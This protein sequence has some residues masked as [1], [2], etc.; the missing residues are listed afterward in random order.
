MA[1]LRDRLPP[2]PLDLIGDV[3]GELEALER[4]LLR[5]G[6]D[7]DR[8]TSARPLIFLGDLIDRGPDSPGVVR[9]V[10][11]LM[12]AG[13]AWCVLG[14]HELNVLLERRREGNGWWWADPTDSWQPGG[15]RPPVPF[16]CA[17]A[18]ADAR[19]ELA[20]L[21]ARMPLTLER[22]DLRV[23]H[24]CWSPEALARL[25]ADGDLAD[26]HRAFDAEVHA[27]L[28]A[29][30]VPA[31]ARAERAAFAGLRDRGTPPTRHLPAAAEED[32]AEQNG[33]PL[34]VLTS[35][36]EREIAPEAVFWVGGRW[37]LVERSPWW[38]A[39]DDPTPVVVGHY[40][41]SRGEAPEDQRVR[42]VF[43]APGPFHWTGKHGQ[44][45]CVDY[46]VGRRYR[47]RHFGGPARGGLAALRWP[48]R[49]LVFD[50]GFTPGD[51]PA[52]AGDLRPRPVPTVGFG[53]PAGDGGG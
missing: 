8:G 50:D 20:D 6:V 28:E 36:A 52:P 14:N 49:E 42:M 51:G 39:A 22:P 1:P 4:L 43:D 21:I 13:I 47:D 48:E 3:H 16:P 30:G 41:R 31:R 26:L 25:P 2:G 27:H 37:R 53:Q 17:L 46:S 18:D 23:V 29:R 7:A 19:A 38:A 35:G 34:N 12:D 11:R 32:A 15:G 24:A 9:L 40:W 5:L 44:V 45:F 33:N 10:R